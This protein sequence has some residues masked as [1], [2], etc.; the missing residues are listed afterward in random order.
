MVLH[1]YRTKRIKWEETFALKQQNKKETHV[2]LNA[3]DHG[4][5]DTTP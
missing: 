2:T 5:M 4:I 1:Y 3:T